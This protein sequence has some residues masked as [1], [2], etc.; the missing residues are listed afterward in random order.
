MRRHVAIVGYGTAGQA[1]ALALTHADDNIEVFERV[2][3]D[4]SG[5]V[6][7]WKEISVQE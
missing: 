7:F 3:V 2:G 5:Y 6:A 1:C 4:F